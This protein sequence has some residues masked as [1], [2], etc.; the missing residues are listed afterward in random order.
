[1]SFRIFGGHLEDDL[2]HATSPNYIIRVPPYDHFGDS[3]YRNNNSCRSEPGKN[4][5]AKIFVMS[6]SKSRG[7]WRG[8][9]D[10][11]KVGF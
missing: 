10:R 6:N 2:N 8:A 5:D 9:G 3:E 4:T 11:K 1:M 7:G